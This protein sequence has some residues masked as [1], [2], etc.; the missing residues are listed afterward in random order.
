MGLARRTA[1]S[2]R[3]SADARQLAFLAG[4]P[5]RTGPPA[6]LVRQAIRARLAGDHRLGQEQPATGA[7]GRSNRAD[8]G[9]VH[10]SLRAA[11]WP[12]LS[13]RG[14]LGTSRSETT[15]VTDQLAELIA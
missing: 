5:V 11:E 13:S 1:D 14:D 15:A 10:R 12:C 7:A 9:Q 3:R 2:D 4:R 8:A 6:A